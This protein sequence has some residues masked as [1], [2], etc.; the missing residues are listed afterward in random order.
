MDMEE[1]RKAHGLTHRQLGERLLP[2][3]DPGH[4]RRIALG[5]VWPLPETIEAVVAASGGAI[6]VE[7]MHQRVLDVRR[8]RLKRV[9]PADGAASAA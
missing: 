1:Y 5:L 2:D 9:C 7:A 8:Q 4:V 3:T 6:T